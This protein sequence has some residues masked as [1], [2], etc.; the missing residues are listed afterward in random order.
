ELPDPVPA[1]GK[2]PTGYPITLNFY[3]YARVVIASYS[4]SGAA[5]AVPVYELPPTLPGT[6]NVLSMLPKSPL[7]PGTQYHVHVSGTIAGVTFTRDW[8]F[9][10]VKAEK[11]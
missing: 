10:T 2:Y 9:T 6:E 5:G 1:G 11:G 8:S 4:V 7:S 3:P